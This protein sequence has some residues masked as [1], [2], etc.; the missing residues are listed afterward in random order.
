ME[1]NSIDPNK[2]IYPIG[3]VSEITGVHPRTIR[4]YEQK[5][6]IKPSRRGGKRF[7]SN[8][9][10][11]WLRCLRK[12]LTEDGFN[13]SSIKKMLSMVPCWQI[14]NCEEEV[15]RKCLA[16]LRFSVPCWEVR[17]I[18][19]AEKGIN[20]SECEVYQRGRLELVKSKCPDESK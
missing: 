16:I 14:R 20:C 1:R 19:C 7:Y 11:Q 10:L 5:G 3:V 8:S 6:L 12:L 4:V 15:R 2:P 13:I 18:T 9:D 17:P